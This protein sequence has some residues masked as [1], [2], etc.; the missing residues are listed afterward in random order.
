MRKNLKFASDPVWGIQTS[1]TGA[2][3]QNTPVVVVRDDHRE[4]KEERRFTA[5]K[6]LGVSPGAGDIDERRIGELGLH[7]S[8]VETVDTI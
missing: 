5:S 7:S 8:G 1:M 2:L 3:H 6:E 4:S